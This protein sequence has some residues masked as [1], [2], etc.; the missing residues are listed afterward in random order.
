MGEENIK[1]LQSVLRPLLGDQLIVVSQKVKNLLQPGENYGS[2]IVDIQA[3]IKKNPDAENEDLHLIGKLPP[4]TQAQLD[5]FD[6]SFVF[7]KEIFT[8]SK[9]LPYYRQLEIDNSIGEDDVFDVSPKYYG[10]RMSLNPDCQFDHDAVL[11]LENLKPKGY[12]CVDRRFG[13]DLAHAKCAVK[14]LAHFHALGM[15]TKEKD[16]EFF[17]I[18]TKNATCLEVKNREVFLTLFKQRIEEI[19]NDPELKEYLEACLENFKGFSPDAWTAVPEEPWSTIIHSDFWANNMLYH[20]KDNE[21]E[22]DDI[23]FIDYQNFLFMSPL[24]ELTFFLGSGLDE[25]A[26][27]HIDELIDL[28][29]KSLIERL[30]KLGCNTELYSRESFDKKLVGDAR[31]EFIHSLGHIKI[32]TME[33]AADDPDGKNLVNLMG[34]TRDNDN[35]TKRL[36]YFVKTY[37]EKG[38][39]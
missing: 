30:E 5:M 13:S 31:V 22:P 39:L 26:N 34:S 37:Y 3:Q 16:P 24:R 9:I 8:Y 15:A 35:F 18:L 29:Y 32:M 33:V 6:P 38:W 17:E 1:D 36:R 7:R 19:G 27:K 11:L 2:H 14:A 12:Y 23:K 20:R 21:T 4:K 28:Y 25:N 10:S